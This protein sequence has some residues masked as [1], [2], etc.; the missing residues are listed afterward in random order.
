MM[1]LR[2]H[3][4]DIITNCSGGKL[5]K[6]A[7]RVAM[8]WAT[9]R[10]GPRL[11]PDVGR[12]VEA[13][14]DHSPNHTHI[15]DSTLDSSEP[16]SSVRGMEEGNLDMEDKEQFP[17]LC[18]T[19]APH[20]RSLY[21]GPRITMVEQY[22]ILKGDLGTKTK[23]KTTTVNNTQP[24]LTWSPQ[25]TIIWLDGTKTIQHPGPKDGGGD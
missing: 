1:L 8:G 19:A 5:N 9:K 25:W 3:Y 21:L 7:L 6:K 20:S 14:L 13:L 23:P 16:G 2:D 17:K 12:M 18:K 4:V 22:S 24:N 15:S 10:Y 11:N